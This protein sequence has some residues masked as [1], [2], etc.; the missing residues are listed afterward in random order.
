MLEPG[1]ARGMADDATQADEPEVTAAKAFAAKATDLQTLRDAV[2]DAANV[3]AGLWFS[4]VFVLLYLFIA[5]ALLLI[6]T[7]CY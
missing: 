6:L 1:G 2:A 3:G 7:S 5:R 4:Y